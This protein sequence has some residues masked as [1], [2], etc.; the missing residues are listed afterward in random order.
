MT[1]FNQP[2]MSQPGLGPNIGMNQP[3]MNPNF[4]MSS[5]AGLS[6]S[7][8]GVSSFSSASA[9]SSASAGSIGMMRAKRYA[10]DEDRH[11][12]GFGDDYG[13]DHRDGF[14]RNDRHRGY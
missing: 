2:G 9:S 13:F 3:S 6:P 11:R 1:D 8:S 4:G 7:M 10:H 12:D 5:G 14:D